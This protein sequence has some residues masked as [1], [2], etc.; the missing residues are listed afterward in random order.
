MIFEE[1]L[2]LID[3]QVFAKI[4][5][6]LTTVE[7]IVLEAAWEDEGYDEVASKS[8]YESNYLRGQVAPKLWM[9]L[10]PIIGNGK[11]VS[12]KKLRSILEESVGAPAL[13]L[14]GELNIQ[15]SNTTLLTSQAEIPVQ[16]I[17]ST[18]NLGLI[19]G[20][21]PNAFDFYGRKAE[22]RELKQLALANRCVVLYGPAGVGKSTI[23]ARLVDEMA[24]ELQPSFNYIVWKSVCYAPSLESLID[25]LLK[26]LP[27]SQV[28]EQ[29]LQQS[30]QSK[31]SLLIES[32]QQN[33]CLI[34]L[35]EAEAW[36]QGDRNKGFNI[37]GEKYSQYGLFFRRLVEEF[38]CSCIV[39][40][41]QEPFKDIMKLQNSGRP[42]YSFKL[43]GL[44]IL[45]AK[46]ILGKHNLTS[47]HL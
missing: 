34:V 5:R 28:L 2:K 16:S 24:A 30:I 15:E 27:R 17:A 4:G 31:I 42:A 7:K 12:K 21:P 11:K 36:L 35:D 8:E 19:Q 46:A 1:A 37:Y 22:L 26:V 23:V 20:Q 9:L 10:S 13:H 45:A 38:H 47:K 3:S 43:A 39:L 32:L 44:D 40:T 14:V 6:R 25:D 29:D 33:R 18:P 41:S